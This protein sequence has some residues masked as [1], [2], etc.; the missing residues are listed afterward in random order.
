MWG[1]L[2]WAKTG[3]CNRTIIPSTPANLQQNGWKEN[4]QEVAIAHSKSRP[5]PDSN[6]VVRAVPKQMLRSSTHWF[7]HLTV[8]EFVW[9]QT[10]T[11]SSAGLGMVVWSAPSVDCCIHT[12]P[13]DPHQGGKRTWVRFNQTEQDRCEYTLSVQVVNFFFFK[14]VFPLT[15]IHCSFRLIRECAQTLVAFGPAKFWYVTLSFNSLTVF[16]YPVL[17]YFLSCFIPKKSVT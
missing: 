11:T 3:S 7:I 1:Q 2:K 17:A 12:C 6:A 16:F 4:N 15:P 14:L 8:P 9:N 5:Y 13:K 10:K